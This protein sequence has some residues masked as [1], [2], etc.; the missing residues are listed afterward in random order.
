MNIGRS[1]SRNISPI[2]MP[3]ACRSVGGNFTPKQRIITSAAGT[4]VT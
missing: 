1:N 2:E 3:D 4:S